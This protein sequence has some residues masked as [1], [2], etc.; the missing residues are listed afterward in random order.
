MQEQLGAVLTAF[1]RF[2]RYLNVAQRHVLHG[3]TH[4]C[5]WP[6]CAGAASLGLPVAPSGPPP[7]RNGLLRVYVC[8]CVCVC[9]YVCVCARACVCVCVCM[10]VTSQMC[11][12]VSI[13]YYNNHSSGSIDEQFASRHGE[14]RYE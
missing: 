8:M 2:A 7:A 3:H 6:V 12:M 4:L 11:L 14:D 5:C 9:V 10:C 1:A 13:K